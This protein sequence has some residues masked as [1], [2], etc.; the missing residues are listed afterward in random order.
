MYPLLRRESNAVT[1]KDPR[2]YFRAVP[3]I[4]LEYLQLHS[5]MQSLHLSGS[6]HKV[7][8]VPVKYG[9]QGL[10]FFLL[11][12]FNCFDPHRLELPNCFLFYF[13]S[14]FLIIRLK[15]KARFHRMFASCIR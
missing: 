10:G 14:I 6:R 13:S 9:K 7:R 4:Y 15:I 5:T 12:L 11:F 8:Q 2:E 3:I 1:W